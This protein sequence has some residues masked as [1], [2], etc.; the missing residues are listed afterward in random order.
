MEGTGSGLIWG[1][2]FAFAWRVW[3]KQYETSRRA[4]AQAVSCRIPTAAARVLSQG[5]H[6]G[7][8]MAKVSLGPVFSCNFSFIDHSITCCYVVSILWQRR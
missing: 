1:T 7:F 4:A 6:V 8:M 3:G 5:R 2:I